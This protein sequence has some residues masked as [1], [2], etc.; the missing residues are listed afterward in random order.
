M[1][2]T[3]VLGGGIAGLSAAYYLRNS[4]PIL[5][6]GSSRLGGWIYT[7][8]RKNGILFEHGPRTIRPAGAPGVNTLNLVEELGLENMVTI[9]T[10]LLKEKYSNW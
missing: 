5:I 6:E 1:T 9:N 8:R 4:A 3:V 2:S 7:K 10:L